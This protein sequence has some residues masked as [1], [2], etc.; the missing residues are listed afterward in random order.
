MQELNDSAWR[1][2]GRGLCERGEEEEKKE[3]EIVIIFRMML[4][5]RLPC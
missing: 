5:C 1:G 4:L 2:G 3:G